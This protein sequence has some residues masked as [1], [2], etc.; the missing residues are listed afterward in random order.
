MPDG[1][2]RRERRDETWAATAAIVVEIVSLGDQTYA[3]FDF[4]AGR[5]VTELL[6]LEPGERRV[7]W[8]AAAAGRF[9]ERERSELLG[10]TARQLAAGLSWPENTDG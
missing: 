4:Y 1:G 8:Y 3:K 6:V 9:A 10:A 7:R 2:Y 5:E